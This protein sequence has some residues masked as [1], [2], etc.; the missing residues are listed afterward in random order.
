MAAIDNIKVRD[1]EAKGL[2][3]RLRAWNRVLSPESSGGAIYSVLF[4]RL[5]ENTF[6]DELGDLSERFFG[7]GL[8]YLEPLN[9]FVG[10][11]RVTLQNLMLNPESPWFDDIRTSERENL[12]DI[13]EKS[14]QETAFFLKQRLGPDPSAWRWGSL[15]QVEIKHPLGKVRPLD[16]ILNLGPFEG[17]GHFSTVLQSAVRPG[18]DFNL[19]GWTASN[20]HIY[21]PKNW[22]GSLANIVPGQ[23]G[24]Y[25]N[26]HYD[27]QMELWLNVDH[28]PLYYSKSKV[29]S[30]A[31]RILILK[32]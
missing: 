24:P 20:R 1:T 31:K 18:M 15:H 19:N 13:L 25:G 9:R 11:S 6:R 16:K 3:K 27:D 8:T 22:D 21:D 2:L 30:E 32:P 26:P 23:S 5:L 10:H 17:G 7:G 4:Y 28:H 14:L 29:E 12:S